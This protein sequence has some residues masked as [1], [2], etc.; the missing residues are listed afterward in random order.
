MGAFFI[1]FFFWIAAVLLETSLFAI[2]PWFKPNLFFLF[3]CLLCLRWR[4]FETHILAAFFG[5]TADCFSTIPFGI[6]GF[7]FFLI[8]FFIRWYAV[9]I[10][11]GSNLVSVIV[12][13]AVTLINN[14]LVYFLLNLFFA[15]GDMTFRWLLGLITTEIIPTAILTIPRLYLL[16]MMESRYRVRLAMRKF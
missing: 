10:Y 12:V 5:L 7:S 6:Y 3:P 1:C 9:K 2:V 14:L 15:E 13:S 8:S 4:G 11:Q 16:F